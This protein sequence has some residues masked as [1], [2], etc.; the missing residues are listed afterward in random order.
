M[1]V[2]RLM[3]YKKFTNAAAVLHNCFVAEG[4]MHA[5]FGPDADFRPHARLPEGCRWTRWPYQAA[6]ALPDARR[7][8]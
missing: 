4:R 6:A 7:S 1:P 3:E 8:C 5:S 2:E